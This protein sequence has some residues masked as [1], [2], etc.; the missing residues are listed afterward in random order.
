MSKQT[1][2]IIGYGFTGQSIDRAL[3]DAGYQ[4]IGVR[5]NWNSNSSEK[6]PCEPIEANITEPDTL[7]RLPE[8]SDLVVNC[9]SSGSRGDVDRYRS[10]YYE[11]SRNLIDWL[12]D[13]STQLVVWTGSSSVYGDHEGEWVDETSELHPDSKASEILIKTENLYH[14]AVEERGLPAV[15]LR[16]TGIYGPGRARS[17]RKVQSADGA[18]SLSLEEA[19]YYMN[20]VH[21]RDIGRAIATLTEDPTPGE[22]YNVVDN[23][24]TTR[25]KVYVW[26]SQQ[27]DKPLPKI[28]GGGRPSFSN[29]RVSNQKLVQEYDFEFEYPTFREGYK[30]ILSESR[31]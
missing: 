3:S 23:E 25:R 31:D 24:P 14:D 11:G 20:M 19:N 21:R 15:T 30:E 22:I 27:L 26:L 17:L 2:L 13:Q 29:K 12:S 4:T 8:N 16:I 18:V 28:T 9:V 5:R 10:I 1:A 6:V 7:E